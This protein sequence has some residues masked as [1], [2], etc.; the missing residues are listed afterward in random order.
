M[1]GGVERQYT[2]FSAYTK[3]LIFIDKDENNHMGTPQTAAH[4]FGHS[5]DGAIFRGFDCGELHQH[6]CAIMK[7]FDKIA[8][9]DRNKV[10][11]IGGVQFV[12]GDDMTNVPSGVIPLRNNKHNV[13]QA[14]T[15]VVIA[16]LAKA[17]MPGLSS[18]DL[19]VKE[20]LVLVEDFL[21]SVFGYD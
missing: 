19:I 2:A 20:E 21:Q 10:F 14:L 12:S 8:S 18:S 11:T 13:S 5:L 17:G 4:E 16:E 3:G 6:K 9:T 1:D 15:K 7:E